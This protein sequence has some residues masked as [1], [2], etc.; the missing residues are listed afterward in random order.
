MAVPATGTL[1][2]PSSMSP[3]LMVDLWSRTLSD[4][5]F[6]A[7]TSRAGGGRSIFIDVCP[8]WICELLFGGEKWVDVTEDDDSACAHWAETL[9]VPNIRTRRRW[10][11]HYRDEIEKIVHFNRTRG[12]GCVKQFPA[13]TQTVVI[14]PLCAE[15]RLIKVGGQGFLHTL[16][17]RLRWAAVNSVGVVFAPIA[18]A[19][20]GQG[21]KG[22]LER[23]LQVIQYLLKL[24]ERPDACVRLSFSP[25]RMTVLRDSL[26]KIE[27]SLEKLDEA[28]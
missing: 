2:S 18:G 26:K 15:Y 7:V 9:H 11:T 3:E 12:F 17:V 24:G 25:A 6:R 19:G 14:P 5:C 27:A 13:G 8:I 21:Q 10:E 22:R 28:S 20:L 16:G 23:K 1:V 4:K